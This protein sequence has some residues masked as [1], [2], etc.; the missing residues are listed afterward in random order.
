MGLAAVIMIIIAVGAVE[1]CVGVM[2][3]GREGREGWNG[4]FNV[5]NGIL[6]FL[7]N[8]SF[9]HNTSNK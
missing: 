2:G 7:L 6:D 4:E 5:G 9:V 8:H 1:V 3:V